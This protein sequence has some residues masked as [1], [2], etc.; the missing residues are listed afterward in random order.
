[1]YIYIYILALGITAYKIKL[2]FASVA[3][4]YIS[5]YS[6]MYNRS[7][8]GRVWR[9]LSQEEAELA[10]RAL[11]SH[12]RTPPHSQLCS[13]NNGESHGTVKSSTLQLGR[14]AP[15][16]WLAVAGGAERVLYGVTGR[17]R[18]QPERSLWLYM[19]WSYSSALTRRPPKYRPL[20]ASWAAV[21]SG[22]VANSTKILTRTSASSSS[23]CRSW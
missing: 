22:G 8:R 4:F 17:E 10:A 5:I 3:L 11:L 12:I 15:S 2:L 21:D 6:H 16:G 7:H 1:M 9:S 13:F 19:F 23:L 14:P 20:S 18:T